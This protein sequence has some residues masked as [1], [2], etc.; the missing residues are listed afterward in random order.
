M[1]SNAARPKLAGRTSNLSNLHVLIVDDNDTNR[2]ILEDQM[3][4]WGIQPPAPPARRK[5]WRNCRTPANDR[6]DVVL[7][8]MHMPGMNGITLAEVIK[9]DPSLARARVI[10]LTSLGQLMDDEQLEKARHRRL[11]G[12]TGQTSPAL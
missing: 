7:L 11:P 6:F 2:R 10:I 9:A 4:A 12:Q 5:P 3:Q 8:D 1:K